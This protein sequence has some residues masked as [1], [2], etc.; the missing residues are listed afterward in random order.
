MAPH[1]SADPEPA[2]GTDEPPAG[3]MASAQL[4]GRLRAAGCV[5]AE[6][7]AQI[8]ARAARDRAQLEAWCARR[9]AG[10]PLEH[11]V[12]EVAFAGGTFLV[13]PGTFVPRRRSEYLVER[14]LHAVSAPAG[15]SLTLVEMCCGVGAIGLSAAQEL[16]RRG[17]R[18]DL[19]LADVDPIALH[20]AERNAHRTG[21]PSVR[22]HRGD[23]WSAL[24]PEL[25]GAVDVVMANAPYVPT[26]E[27]VLLPPEAR[28]HEPVAALDGGPDGTDLHHRLADDASRWLR[29]GGVL[30]I[31][32]SD[33]QAAVTA[34][35]LEAA[36]LR[37]RIDRAPARW[38]TAVTGRR[39]GPGRGRPG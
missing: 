24:P 8:L 9:V 21:L 25:R 29:P 32:T 33:G 26:S 39:P 38:G 23:L 10:E 17:V 35:L 37:A 34:G 22:L 5:F 28:L 13:G 1:G 6:E 2:R 3:A 20:W 18:V 11:V 30:V 19:H 27:M 16:H 7:E 4:V 12:G 36:G 31:E 15:P 14:V